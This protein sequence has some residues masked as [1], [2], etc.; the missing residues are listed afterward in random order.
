[1][2]I[3]KDEL[4][5]NISKTEGDLR[6]KEITDSWK[7]FSGDKVYKIAKIEVEMSKGMYVRSLSQDICKK[8]NT[9][10]FTNNIVRTKNGKYIKENCQA[11]LK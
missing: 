10:G 5:K 4:V 2:K 11:I 7:Q 8:L 9:V 6:Q 3:I 1:M